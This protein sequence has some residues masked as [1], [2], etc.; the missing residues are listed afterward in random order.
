[1]YVR[2]MLY[3]IMSIYAI[4]TVKASKVMRIRPRLHDVHQLLTFDVRQVAAMLLEEVEVR[5]QPVPHKVCE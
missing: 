5:G 1:M 4:N 2:I 3:M